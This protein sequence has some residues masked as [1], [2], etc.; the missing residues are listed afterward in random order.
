MAPRFFSVL[1][2]LIRDTF[3]QS[4]ASGLGKVAA[5]LTAVATLVCLSAEVHGE[6]KFQSED[7][8]AVELLPAG[9]IEAAKTKQDRGVRIIGNRL[10]LLFGRMEVPLAR[11]A[12]DAVRFLHYVFASGVCESLGLFLAL[13]WT[14]GFIPTF[15]QPSNV[16][17]LLTKRTPRWLLLVGKYIGVLLFVAVHAG[18]FVLCTW[19]ALGIKTQV[20]NPTYLAAAPLLLVQ[21]AAFFRVFSRT[22][23]CVSQSDRLRARGV[24]VLGRLFGHQW[25]PP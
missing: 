25:R 17:V 8:Q 15:L 16:T 9:D 14:A 2:W 5:V 12:D 13:I 18:A 11:D 10:T 6:R 7:G 4:R 21:F 20:W 1:G 23:D 19:T 3:K 22:G 24:A